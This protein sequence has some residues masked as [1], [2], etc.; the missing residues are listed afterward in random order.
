[1]V[2]YQDTIFKSPFIQAAA[3]KNKITK[4]PLR[5]NMFYKKAKKIFYHQ[6]GRSLLFNLENKLY[7]HEMHNQLVCVAWI[8]I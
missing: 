2:C 3:D 4:I 1:M 6:V 8:S 5:F 7:L